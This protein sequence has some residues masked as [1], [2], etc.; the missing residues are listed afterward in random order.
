MA[1]GDLPAP[2]A[3]AH[4]GWGRSN[5]AQ[6]SLLLDIFGLPEAP[7]ALAAAAPDARPA[8]DPVAWHSFIPAPRPPGEPEPWP[9]GKGPGR[10]SAS[11]RGG[12]AGAELAGTRVD[13]AATAGTRTASQ[14]VKQPDAPDPTRPEMEA[15]CNDWP[16]TH[17]AAC[18]AGRPGPIRAADWMRTKSLAP[19]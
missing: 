14:L 15:H 2:D 5:P 11:R 10:S 16:R 17:H 6:R 4:A 7:P 9:W 13:R 1:G 18:P 12:R 3:L 8:P 19:T